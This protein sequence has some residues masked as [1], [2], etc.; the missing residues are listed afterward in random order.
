MWS[1]TCR[2]APCIVSSGPA[3]RLPG[4]VAVPIRGNRRPYRLSGAMDA[5]AES[6]ASASAASVVVHPRNKAPD[7]DTVSRL[8]LPVLPSGT[9]LSSLRWSS[10]YHQPSHRAAHRHGDG[11]LLLAGDAAHIHPPVGG[12][13]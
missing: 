3:G 4:A 2:A 12:R 9:R 11:R 5:G 1:G 6:A 8:L 13:T 10:V 7:L